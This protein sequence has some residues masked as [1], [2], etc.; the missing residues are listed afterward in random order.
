MRKIFILFLFLPVFLPVMA[1]QRE[2]PPVDKTLSPYFFVKSDNPSVDSLPLKSTSAKVD[3][4]GVIA[5]VTVTQEYRN[6]GKVPLEATYIFPASTRAAVYGMKMTIGKRTLTA[7]IEERRKARQDYEQARNEGRSASLLEQQRPNVFQ[8]SVAN[9]MPGDTVKV[10]LKYTELLVP[11]DGVYRFVYPTV[12]GPRYSETPDTPGQ[13]DQ[14]VKNPYLH[15]GEAPPYTF[16][17]SVNISS[18]I[19]VQDVFSPSHKVNVAFDGPK[20]AAIR[21]DKS[22]KNGGNRDFILNYR[23]SGKKI[24]SGL[25]LYRGKGENFFLLMAEPP[26]RV[27]PK[28]IPPRDY[29]FVMDVSGSM[30]GFPLNIS[31]T[32]IKNLISSLRPTDTFDILLFSGGSRLLSPEPLPATKENVHKA[33]TLIDSLNGGG[34]TRLLPA[35]RQALALPIKDGVSRSIVVVTDGYVSVEQ[36]TFQLIRK[37][38]N[39]A[40]L[41]AFGIGTSVNRYLIEGMARAG[42]GEPF[43]ITSP[44][45]A[46]AIA[47]KFRNYIL[48]PVLTDIKVNFKGFDT[49]D[50]EPA[51]IPDLFAGRPVVVFGKWKGKAA[52]KVTV[53]GISGEGAYKAEFP[54]TSRLEKKENAPL[55]YLWARTRIAELSDYAKFNESEIKPEV[56]KLGL[57]YNLMTAY[58]SF[59]AIDTKIRNKDGKRITVKQPLPLPQGVA[60]TAVGGGRFQKSLSMSRPQYAVGMAPPA[61]TGAIAPGR[62]NPQIGNLGVMHVKAVGF[63]QN[64]VARALKKMQSQLIR[65]L[66]PTGTRQVHISV[67]VHLNP[68][69]NQLISIRVSGLSAAAA[70]KKCV[71]PQLSQL[72]HQLKKSSGSFSFDIFL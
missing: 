4:A 36:A 21:L 20:T 19:P 54:V 48:S 61:P 33:V 45:K 29:I 69:G 34:G 25:M 28:I 49:Y 43:V 66:Q 51:S 1:G 23:L 14:W 67:A 10:E 60:D 31:K 70:F 32:L 2:T 18:P 59:V 17:I 62:R 3:I 42:L 6:V 65:C 41:F 55:R 38:L 44:G 52:G 15:Q 27:K 72:V 57:K 53:T 35:M 8:M 16:G 9:I 47:E 7:K 26:K 12:V 30:R 56:T 63:S 5:D 39:H 64:R 22:E 40:N 11:T 68:D 37:N 50:V 46:P 71:Q 24:Q 58:T 13:K